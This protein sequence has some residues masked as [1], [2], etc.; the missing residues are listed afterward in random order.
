MPIEIKI[1]V[2]NAEKPF[3]FRVGQDVGAK[4]LGLS[5]RLLTPMSDQD[6]IS[7]YNTN[8]ISTR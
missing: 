7:P 1:S 8:T 5:C 2:F 4:T 3:I 6:R